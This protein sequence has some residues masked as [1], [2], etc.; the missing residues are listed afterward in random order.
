V[1]QLL[2]WIRPQEYHGLDYGEA[3]LPAGLPESPNKGLSDSSRLTE[4]GRMNVYNKM[5]YWSTFVAL[6]L[7]AAFLVGEIWVMNEFPNLNPYLVHILAVALVIV[8]VRRIAERRPK[9][10]R[11]YLI[12]PVTG[13]SPDP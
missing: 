8:T 6:V 9:P 7:L 13:K 10:G 3:P 11:K 12:D 1:R 5:G 2:G 4:R